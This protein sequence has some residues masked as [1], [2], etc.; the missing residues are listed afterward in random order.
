MFSVKKKYKI[1]F[2]GPEGYCTF[3]QS[4]I[5]TVSAI[6]HVILL[7][8]MLQRDH[9]FSRFL[10]EK[11]SKVINAKQMNVYSLLI[12]CVSIKEVSRRTLLL[13]ARKMI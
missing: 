13:V 2:E 10:F 1:D 11:I 5:Q 6:F 8:L 7:L 4:P 12:K 9:T 3:S